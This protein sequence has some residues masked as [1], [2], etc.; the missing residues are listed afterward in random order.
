MIDPNPVEPGLRCRR[1]KASQ[2]SF[3]TPIA[4]M[5]LVALLAVGCTIAQNAGESSIYLAEPPTST[6]S[7]GGPQSY[8]LEFSGPTLASHWHAA[9][10]IRI[11]DD[12][13]A[14]FTDENDPLGIHTH[15]DGL[16]HVHP[17]F[18]EAAFENATL[19]LFAD[20]AGFVIED[21]LIEIPG[22][23]VWRDGDPC[24]GVP[25]R[26]SIDR[27]AA[28]D[29][30]EP[31]ELITEDVRSTRFLTDGELFTI[32][33]APEGVIPTRPPNAFD[34]YSLSPRLG[35][36]QGEP[37]VVMPLE[38]DPGS[39]AMWP[40]AEINEPPCRPDQL[41]Q[42]GSNVQAL[43]FTRADTV[44]GPS[45]VVAAKAY[46]VGTDPGIIIDLEP[47]TIDQ[48]N[49]IIEQNIDQGGIQLAFELNDSV[50]VGATAQRPFVD[51]RITLAGGMSAN[52]AR[53]LAEALNP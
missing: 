41:Q 33:F 12:V 22:R 8:G 4:T 51:N 43:C 13:I 29:S 2:R 31:Y 52:T 26:L 17:F 15:G 6:G 1:V 3:V 42:R 50:I 20:A 25:G 47:G 34:L 38:P 40:I 9:Y 16:I 24:G 39:F 32:T 37:S 10:V 14:P 53:A 44:F 18:S 48:L 23:G 30:A 7:S 45:A 49:A 27:W 36:P 46:M 28:P 35:Q 19:G 11:C 21:G 5:L